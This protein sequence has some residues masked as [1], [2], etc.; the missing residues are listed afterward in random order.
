MLWN[1]IYTQRN[2]LISLPAA[3]LLFARGI[4]LLPLNRVVKGLFWS[5]L[6]AGSSLYQM[7][8]IQAYYKLPNKEQFRE[9]VYQIVEY[10]QQFKD[11]VVL[12]QVRYSEYLEY[13]F[14]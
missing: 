2:L 11:S 8:Y 5:A 10:E 12:G 14:V 13:Y 3:Y 6:F 1:P 4:V 7:L 9:A